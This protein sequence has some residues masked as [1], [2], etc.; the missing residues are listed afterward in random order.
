M[1]LLPEGTSGCSC[2]GDGRRFT[3]QRSRSDIVKSDDVV[4]GVE[5]DE[6]VKKLLLYPESVKPVMGAGP[7]VSEGLDVCGGVG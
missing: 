5:S 3:I 2:E 7:F 6:A 1:V 4:Q